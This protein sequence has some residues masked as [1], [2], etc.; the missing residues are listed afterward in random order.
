VIDYVAIDKARLVGS[1]KV[2]SATWT[3]DKSHDVKSVVLTAWKFSSDRFTASGGEKRD[4]GEFSID[5]SK[6]PK[7]INLT[8]SKSQVRVPIRGIYTLEG[9]RLKIA[10]T[11]AIDPVSAEDEAKLNRTRPSTWNPGGTDPTLVITMEREK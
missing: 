8:I 5:P 7:H 2:T 10:W 9:Q 1:W 4:E 11:T 6:S 3:F